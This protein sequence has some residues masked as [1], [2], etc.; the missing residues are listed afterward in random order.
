VIHGSPR[1]IT[2]LKSRPP[3]LIVLQLLMFFLAT[4]AF[5]TAAP[6]T[7]NPISPSVTICTPASGATLNSPVSVAAGTTNNA[8][9]VT[10]MILYVDNEI[11]Y[12]VQANQ[13]ST[14]VTLSSGDH[15]LTV[16]AWDSSGAVFK[17]TVIVTVSGAGTSPVS[18]ETTPSSAT[19]APGDTQE[20]TATI[21]NATDTDV[22]WSVDGLF[23]GNINVGTI[24][25]S[26]LYTAPATS[27]THTIVATSAADPTKSDTVIVTVTSGGGGPC[28]PASGPP[29]VTICSPAS[30]STVASPV[31]IS[32]VG[33]SVE[34]STDALEL[35]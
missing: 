26:G 27:G 33:N 29:S 9:P 18:V 1:A 21:L 5:A 23:N 15:N 2:S 12:K 17:S 7:L 28:S 8:Y 30:G 22:T 13:L 4:A 35:Q 14:S 10:A 6:C 31:Q 20:F 19:L 16:N 32:A 11:A 3:T 25:D 24:T 34:H